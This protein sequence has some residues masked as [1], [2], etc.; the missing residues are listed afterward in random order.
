MIILRTIIIEFTRR[1]CHVGYVLASPRL[2]YQDHVSKETLGF[3]LQPNVD[4][5]KA[6]IRIADVGT[7]TMFV[8]TIFLQSFGFHRVWVHDLSRT[9]PNATLPVFD[10]SSDQYP[11]EG[12][13]GISN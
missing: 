3:V 11:T 6:Y 7:G 1:G 10:I 13:L 12:F 9:M 2:N 4:T 5:S 8:L